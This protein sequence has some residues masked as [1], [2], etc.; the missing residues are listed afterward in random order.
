MTLQPNS[1]LTLPSLVINI[2]VFFLLVNNVASTSSTSP[3]LVQ[4]CGFNLPSVGRASYA[5]PVRLWDAITGR[6]TDFTTHF[7][8][9]VNALSDTYYGDDISFF[10]APFGSNI[11]HNSSGGYFGLFSSDSTFDS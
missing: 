9:I 4:T 1:H 5:Q 11:P 3:V 8:F 2:F 10:I 6:L 7:N